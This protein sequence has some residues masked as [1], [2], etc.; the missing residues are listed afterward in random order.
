MHEKWD[1]EEIGQNQETETEWID[2]IYFEIFMLGRSMVVI[3]R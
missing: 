2:L 1:T 3:D